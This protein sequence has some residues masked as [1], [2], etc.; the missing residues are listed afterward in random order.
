MSFNQ[1]WRS[2]RGC[3][4]I[5]QFCLHLPLYKE[6]PFKQRFYGI[7]TKQIIGVSIPIFVNLTLSGREEWALNTLDGVWENISEITIA[8][9][10]IFR[11]LCTAFI[12]QQIFN[13]IDKVLLI[14]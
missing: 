5:F 3:R 13:E 10:L 7:Y 8:G 2:I 1:R 6:V 14:Q 4:S 12:Q 9:R 11:D